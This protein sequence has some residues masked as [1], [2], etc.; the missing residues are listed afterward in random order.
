MPTGDQAVGTGGFMKDNEHKRLLDRID[1][2][3]GLLH[4]CIPCVTDA[5]DDPTNKQS[6]K[7]KL[8]GLHLRIRSAL[9]D[10]SWAVPTASNNVIN[11]TAP[12]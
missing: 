4:E 7:Q 1:L 8:R 12:Q 10:S 3:D 2:L 9:V 6:G 5:I 11:P